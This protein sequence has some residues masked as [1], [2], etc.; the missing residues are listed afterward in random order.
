MKK[1]S[2]GEGTNVAETKSEE[3]SSNQQQLKSSD[4]GRTA[5]FETPESDLVEADGV[6]SVSGTDSQTETS[7]SKGTVV[8]SECGEVASP[9]S[10]M[11]VTAVGLGDNAEKAD[12]VAPAGKS[13]S[14]TNSKAED[15]G[16]SLP[17]ASSEL[18]DQK[19]GLR[20][21]DAEGGE[22]MDTT[23]PELCDKQS[24]KLT[25]GKPKAV[26][27]T[28]ADRKRQHENGTPEYDDSDDSQPPKR[29]RLDEVIGKLGER[30]MIPSDTP[31]NDSFECD[32]T[33]GDTDSVE[34][35]SEEISGSTSDE[36][37]DKASSPDAKTKLK[38]TKQ[39]NTVTF[40]LPYFSPVVTFSLCLLRKRIRLKNNEG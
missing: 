40:V 36:E 38:I 31:E 8:K 14:E 27:K 17:P 12:I 21:L 10:P 6:Q 30:V 25:E 26:D 4:G 15:T 9:L 35:H 7:S 2:N 39:V 20:E 28:D 32:S 5:A 22:S 11:K 16:S 18:K 33:P 3:L 29:S 19:L 24:E 1:S 23:E 34:K 37:E 13:T